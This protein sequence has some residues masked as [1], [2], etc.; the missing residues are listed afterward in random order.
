MTRNQIF[1]CFI[2]SQFSCIGTHEIKGSGKLWICKPARLSKGAFIYLF[3]TYNEMEEEKKRIIPAERLKGSV[4]KFVVQEY[5]THPLLVHG[6]KFDLRLYVLVQ[7]FWPLKAFIYRFA[8]AA[9]P[10]FLWKH[11]CYSRSMHI[12]TLSRQKFRVPN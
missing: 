8:A 10:C 2:I 9:C 11:C 5:I 3:R 1:V 4:I 6:Y 12:L 7:S